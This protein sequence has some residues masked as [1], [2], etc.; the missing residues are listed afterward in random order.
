VAY[1]YPLEAQLW[2]ECSTPPS[3]RNHSGES[4]PISSL[5]EDRRGKRS[6]ATPSKSTTGDALGAA[7]SPHCNEKWDYD[8][9][10]AIATLSGFEILCPGCHAVNHIGRTL[11]HGHGEAAIA[12]FCKVNGV[13]RTEADQVVRQAFSIWNKRSQEE[14]TVR[15]RGPWFAATPNFAVCRTSVCKYHLSLA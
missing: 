11:K 10:N 14:W 1:H 15:V 8:D 12:H 9:A 7:P 3:Y 2:I 6:A 5:N 4:A 13:T